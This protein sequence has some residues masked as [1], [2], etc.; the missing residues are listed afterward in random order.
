MILGPTTFRREG[1]YRFVSK[2]FGDHIISLD[3]SGIPKII[4]SGG[5]RF[6]IVH[7]G[8]TGEKGTVSLASAAFPGHYLRHRN[9]LL[10]LDP[11]EEN[12]VYKPDATFRL[13]LNKFYQVCFHEKFIR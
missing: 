2:N 3:D 12:N 7:P 8:L 6:Y 1:P 4:D 10:H 13:H 5:D 9:Y 11:Y